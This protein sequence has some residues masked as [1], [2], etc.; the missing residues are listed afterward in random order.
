MLYFQ[1]LSINLRSQ[2]VF[3]RAEVK[4][5]LDNKL[6]PGPDPTLPPQREAI[7]QWSSIVGFR[8]TQGI[9]PGYNISKHAINGLTR[10]MA[11]TYGKDGIRTNAVAPG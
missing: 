3:S 4:A 5:M 7:V 11:A 1:I 10:V 6:Q 2:I 8:S 9:Q